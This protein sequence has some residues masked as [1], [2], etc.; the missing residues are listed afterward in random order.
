MYPEVMKSKH[1][2]FGSK[3]EF[4]IDCEKAKG[5]RFLWGSKM[6]YVTSPASHI[7]IVLVVVDC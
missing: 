6:F 1:I 7:H 3:L 2:V 5:A 4:C